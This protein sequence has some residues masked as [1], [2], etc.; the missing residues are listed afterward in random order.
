MTLQ[1]VH[2]P[3]YVAP[4]PPGHSFPMDKYGLVMV[5][6]AEL[7]LGGTH[8][9]PEPMPREWLESVHDPA[10]V[11]Q[12]LAARVDRAHEKR[13]GFPVTPRVSRRSQLA[14]GGTWLAAMLA[15]RHGYAANSA[16]G[17]HHA[18][19]DG[20]AGYCVMNDMAAA[21]M[22]LLGEGRAKRIL[23][24]DLD[25][26]QG[27]GTARIF[28]REDRVFTFS[29][30]GQNNYPQDKARSS[31]DIG[32]A[33]G[34]GDEAY[35]ARLTQE[36]N[37]IVSGFRPDVVLYQAGVDCH[38]DDRLGRLALTDEGIAARDRLVIRACLSRGIPVASVLGGGYGTDRMAVSRRHA[39]TIATLAREAERL[40]FGH[41]PALA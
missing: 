39:A 7:G 29:V 16:G 20:G 14:V 10:Y 38:R 33:D 28:E 40:G 22:R 2:H 26:H 34:T 21:A 23:I 32:L 15:I 11:A 35:L 3:D 41:V 27:D 19:P 13:I 12:V 17:S 25:V 5:A 37:P 18:G 31:R 24:V 30:H 36:L 8:H 9:T 6:L 1:L 4:L